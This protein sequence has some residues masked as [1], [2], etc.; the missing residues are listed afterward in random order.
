[1]GLVEPLARDVIATGRSVNSRLPLVSAPPDVSVWTTV[2]AVAS[3]FTVVVCVAT[4][5]SASTRLVSREL[6]AIVVSSTFLET[7]LFDRDLVRS[8]VQIHELVTTLYRWLPCCDWSAGALVPQ[9]TKASVTTLP[10]GSCTVPRI[11]P[12]V[13]WPKPV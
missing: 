8:D 7:R 12:E 13:D 3:T 6:S 5:R 2:P 9:V 10:P 4:W 1:M 11:V